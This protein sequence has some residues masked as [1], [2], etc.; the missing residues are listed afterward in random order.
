[1]NQ[2]L[3]RGGWGIAGIVLVWL[4]VKLTGIIFAVVSALVRMTISVLLAA[5]VL[6][7]VYVAVSRVLRSRESGTAT[8]FEQEY[9]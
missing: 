1:M 7:V 2:W 6:F 4:L 9:Q 8:E 5:V 3:R